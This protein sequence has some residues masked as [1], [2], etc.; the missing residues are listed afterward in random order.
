MLA[1]EL[2]AELLGELSSDEL[3]VVFDES[4][5]EQVRRYAGGDFVVRLTLLDIALSSDA[6]AK[7]R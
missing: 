1:G 2:G 3:P 4:D 5:C 7:V 6:F